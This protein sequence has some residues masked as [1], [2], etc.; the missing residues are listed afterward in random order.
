MDLPIEFEKRMKDMLKN[1]YT[2]F[3]NAY[4]NNPVYSG[5][6]IN[7]NKKNAKQLVLSEFGALE[8]VSWCECGYYADKSKIS[9]KH[10]Y[11]M[12]GLFYFQEPSAMSCGDAI[13]INEGDYVLDLCAAPGGKSTQVAIR[14]NGTGLLVSNEI[15]KKRAVI[16]SE[17]IERMGL[18]NVIVTN[19]SPK[20]LEEKY[21]CFFDKIIVDAPCSGEGMFRKEDFFE[22]DWSIEHTVSCSERQKNILSS[23]MKMLKPG[24]FIV[25][26]TCT[27]SPE[28]NEMIVDYLLDN[29]PLRLEPCDNLTMVS[30]GISSLSKKGYDMSHAR[31]IFPHKNKGEGH[32]IALFRHTGTP[33]ENKPIKKERKKENKNT[34]KINDNLSN[35]INVYREFENK[36]LNIHLDGEFISFGDNLYLKPANIDIDKIK[37]LRAGLHLGICKKGRFEPSHSL[38]LSLSCEDFK[39]I[40][41]F[42]ANDNELYDYLRGNVIPCSNIGWTAVTIDYCPIGW[43]KA[44]NGILKNHYPKGMRIF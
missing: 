13:P 22:S 29:Y 18:K 19:E 2:D 15:I 26:S 43:G 3:L 36:F 41:N 11:H 20:K 31:R 34:S 35:M 28:E 25:Y 1:E 16:L 7:E 30:S 27:F 12:A 37:V 4:L 9:G 8:K 24:G 33:C 6:R 32:F 42:T 38:V 5:I 44:N 14:L 10:P 21:P 39:N 23:A 17:N 40:I